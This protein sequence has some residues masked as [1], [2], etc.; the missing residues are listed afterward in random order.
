MVYARVDDFAACAEGKS[1]VCAATAR[2]DVAETPARFPLVNVH[3][4]LKGLLDTRNPNWTLAT[5]SSECPHIATMVP[6][7]HDPAVR[8]SS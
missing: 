6:A 8:R 2:A 7:L 5:P 1:G 3:F 4:S